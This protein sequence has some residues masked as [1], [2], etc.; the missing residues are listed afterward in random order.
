MA[1]FNLGICYQNGIG[2][3][4]DEIKAFEFFKKSAEK[5]C[6]NAQCQLGECYR[7]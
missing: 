2:V 7:L 5:K 3:E 4:K 6:V 1:Q